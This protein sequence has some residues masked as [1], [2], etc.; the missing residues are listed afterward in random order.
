MPLE[1]RLRS[2]LR[3]DAGRPIA[4]V[5]AEAGISRRCLAKWCARRR[6]HGENGLLGHSSRPATRPAAAARRHTRVGDRSPQPGEARTQPAP[7]PRSTNWRAA[8]R[9]VP[10]PAKSD[11]CTSIRRSTTTPGSPTP[12]SAAA[13]VLLDP[14]LPH[15]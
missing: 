5:A 4:Y 8:A 9:G 14:P 3:I 2:C 7:G 12:R 13:A 15:R 1:G 6:A 10:A 11:T